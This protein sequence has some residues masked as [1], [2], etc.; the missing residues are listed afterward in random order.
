MII[1]KLILDLYNGSDNFIVV[2]MWHL[3]CL[4]CLSLHYST[5]DGK[6]RDPWKMI[7]L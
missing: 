3:P 6:K 5:R 7:N 2:E 1:D 4:I